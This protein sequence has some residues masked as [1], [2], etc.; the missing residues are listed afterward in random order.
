MHY[1]VM[2]NYNVEKFYLQDDGHVNGAVII[3]LTFDEC[4][5]VHGA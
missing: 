3:F 1:S 2:E 5:L 4:C